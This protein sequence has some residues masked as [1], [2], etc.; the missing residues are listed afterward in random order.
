MLLIQ[1]RWYCPKKDFLQKDIFVRDEVALLHNKLRNPFEEKK[2]ES[3]LTK[4]VIS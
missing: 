4:H 3:L 2:M 1:L